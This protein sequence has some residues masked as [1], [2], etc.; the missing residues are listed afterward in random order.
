MTFSPDG[1][2]LASGGADGTVR[3][4]E[5]ARGDAV[6]V[7]RGHEVWQ[8]PRGV[9]RTEARHGIPATGGGV[10]G[11]GRRRIDRVSV[12]SGGDVEEIGGVARRIGTDLVQGRVDE[13]ESAPVDLVGDRDETRPLRR[14]QRGAADVPPAARRVSDVRVVPVGR[15]REVDEGAGTGA[16]L[17]GDVGDSARAADRRRAGGQRVLVVGL[18]VDVTEASARERPA[19][20][21]LVR[22]GV[23][24]R[25]AVRSVRPRLIG[26]RERI[27][28]EIRP[29]DGRHE[30][31][32]CRPADDGEAEVGAAGC[33]RRLLLPRRPVVTRR[34]EN[35]DALGGCRLER[36]AEVEQ[37]SAAAEGVFGGA[38][39][40]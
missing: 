39:A 24:P 8:E 26:C 10:A 35:R 29:S 15:E 5:A 33:D 40:L 13:A 12:V 1:R 34:G 22:E 2:R 32:G 9:R 16:R 19:H 25:G 6:A 17:V 38:E 27:G 11:Y 36:V 14:G 20:L 7:C 30:R 18:R 3:L 23:A 4:W 28:A 31:V 37:R 21:G